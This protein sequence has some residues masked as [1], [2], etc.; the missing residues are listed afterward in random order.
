[1]DTIEMDRFNPLVLI[2]EDDPDDQ[3]MLHDAFNEA[4]PDCQ[5]KFVGDGVELIERLTDDSH[6]AHVPLPDLLLLDLNMP[7]KDG[8]QALQELRSNPCFATLPIV[9]LTTS[10]SDEDKNAC[11]AAGANN[12]V[13]KPSSFTELLHIVGTLQ[14][15]W[16]R[17]D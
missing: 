3:L 9:V 1:M 8:R 13:V 15:Y 2:A 4:C 7:L 6:S 12:Y 16:N 5:L 17:H 10:S 11:I 14:Q